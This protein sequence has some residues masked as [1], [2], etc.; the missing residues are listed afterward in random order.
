[1]TDFV[2]TPQQLSTLKQN[3]QETNARLLTLE[4]GWQDLMGDVA[5]L[6]SLLPPYCSFET[7]SR[8]TTGKK[9]FQPNHRFDPGMLPVVGSILRSSPN[10]SPITRASAVH[11]VPL[12]TEAQGGRI[13][14]QRSPVD[15]ALEPPALPVANDPRISPSSSIV[16][17]PGFRSNAPSHD[18][19]ATSRSLLFAA[20]SPATE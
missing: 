9:V 15:H 8:N 6:M 16:R 17:T 7:S 1:M 20:S 3:L 5:V 2:M 10:R 11:A 12:P 19:S 14:C 13:R 18:A 4:C